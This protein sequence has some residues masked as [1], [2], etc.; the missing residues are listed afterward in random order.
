MS[1]DGEKRAQGIRA[2][3]TEGLGAVDFDKAFLRRRVP[4]PEDFD[5]LGHVNNTVYVR[6][7]QEIAVEH[8]TTVVP[9]TL[10]A[11]VLWVI[12]RHEIDYRDAIEPGDT[13]E[14][15][16]WLGGLRGPR[17]ER[18][19]DIRKPGAARPAARALTTWCLLDA[20]TKRPRRVD[21]RILA[22]FG[23]APDGTLA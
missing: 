3:D 14:L 17:Y 5:V 6:W 2:Q 4:E 20:R 18:H 12:L 23:L 7:V 22:A 15:R 11:E 1:K 21:E 19:V 9:E 8:W 13:A 10:Q 16:T